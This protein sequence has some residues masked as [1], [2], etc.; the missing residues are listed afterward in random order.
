MTDP[1][2]NLEDISKKFTRQVVLDHV[3]LEIIPGD[4]I[5]LIGQNGAGKTTMIRSILGQYNCEGNI[6]VA[7]RQ[8]RKDRVEVLQHIGFVPQHPPPI[9]MSVQELIKF[10]AKLNKNSEV[11]QIIQVAEDLGFEVNAHK[12][13]PFLKLSGG[14]KQKLLIAMAL[15]KNPTV[16]IMDEPAA[17]LD[18]AGRKAFFLRLSK[19][20][21][22]TTMILSSHRVD[23][24]LSLINRIIEMD[25]GKIVLDERTGKHSLSGKLLSCKVKVIDMTDPIKKMLDDWDFQENSEDLC[26]EGQIV[27][28]DRLR[29]LNAISHFANHIRELNIT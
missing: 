19:I 10:S 4:R 22:Q 18:P 28:V 3:H 23:E 21:Q 24:L 2:I 1:I 15:A 8:P 6:S 5:A 27:D 9:Q 25:Y 7:G 17:N 26:Y 12:R 20:H 16:L 29:F 14:M 11:Q 13:K